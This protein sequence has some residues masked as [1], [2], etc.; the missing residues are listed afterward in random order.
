MAW[1]ESRGGGFRVRWRTLAGEGRSRQCPD[2]RSARELKA[3]VERAHAAGREWTPEVD[4]GAGPGL[5]DV[6]ADYLIDAA[7]RLKPGTVARAETVLAMFLSAAPDVGP[8]GLSVET[9][10]RWHGGLLARGV[11]RRTAAAYLFTVAHVWRWAYDTERW[12]SIVPRPRKV[13]PG[14]VPPSAHVEAPS[15]ADID[16]AIESAGTGATRPTWPRRLM[17]FVRFTGLR[18]GQVRRLLWTDLDIDALRID[19]RPELGKTR[20]EQRGRSIPMHPALAAELAG[21]GR[22][23]GLVVDMRGKPIDYAMMERI[24]TEAAVD[25]R[26]PFHGIRHAISGW[27]RSHGAAEDAI[28]RLIGHAGTITGVHY[29]GMSPVWMEMVAAVGALPEIGA[30]GVSLDAARKTPRGRQ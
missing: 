23:E 20:Q 16:R 3:D 18:A 24:Y 14:P 12:G 26:Q 10:H 15:L 5:D 13:D 29:I 25:T 8:A 6:F 7:R 22:R 4:G 21:W 11:S 17:V 9:L 30:A 1:I 27:M 2:R 19:V 28:G